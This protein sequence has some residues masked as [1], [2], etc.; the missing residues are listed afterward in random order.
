MFA[1]RKRTSIDNAEVLRAARD[2][3]VDSL[4][5]TY[6][7]GVRT[8]DIIQDQQ[9][10]PDMELSNV[11]EDLRETSIRDTLLNGG[12]AYPLAQADMLVPSTV[13]AIFRL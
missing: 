10:G 1:E 13:A 6:T 9:F 2:G 7:T 11:H 4:M 3:R 8:S 5:F 12:V